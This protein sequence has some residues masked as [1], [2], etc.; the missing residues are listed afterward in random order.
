MD[1]KAS[2]A[3][4][5]RQKSDSG[6][7]GHKRLAA[8]SRRRSSKSSRELRVDPPE[9]NLPEPKSNRSVANKI[10]RRI[11]LDRPLLNLPV[12]FPSIWIAQSA[13]TTQASDLRKRRSQSA[14][15]NLRHVKNAAIPAQGPQ[16]F[17][18]APLRGDMHCAHGAARTERPPVSTDRARTAKS[19]DF[20]DFPSQILQQEINVSQS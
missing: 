10:Y 15:T 14:S 2:M 3:A 6:D 1:S 12:Q 19:T 4:Q 7:A 18:K 5:L 16:T 11:N 20:L 8:D 13:V 9:P 17:L